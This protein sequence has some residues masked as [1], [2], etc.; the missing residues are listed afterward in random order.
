MISISMI[1]LF[2]R[3]CL[4]CL[5]LFIGPIQ[6]VLRAQE[7]CTIV[8]ASVDKE[9][10]MSL[11]QTLLLQRDGRV[12]AIADSDGRFE[13]KIDQTDSLNL[14]AVHPA[15]HS[16]YIQVCLLSGQT[17]SLPIEL[18]PRAHQLVDLS[19]KKIRPETAAA[20]VS[21]SPAVTGKGQGLVA[22]SVFNRHTGKPVPDVNVFIRG[23]MTHTRTDSIGNFRLSIPADTTF[24]LALSHKGYTKDWFSICAQE[25]QRMDIHFLLAQRDAPLSVLASNEDL[26]ILDPKAFYLNESD[27]ESMAPL[28][29]GDFLYDQL[30]QLLATR[31]IAAQRNRAIFFLYADRIQ[32]NRSFLNHIDPFSIRRIALWGASKAPPRY[33][34][35]MALFVV[36]IVTYR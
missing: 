10:G 14:V 7:K 3:L 20:T 33:Q 2:L 11:P 32:W 15:Y 23:T 24:I 28:S 4:P 21:S 9:N 31:D 16:L 12:L 34:T 17:S 8:G 18:V 29:F 26:E 25:N 19:K 36:E 27:I 5:L 1:R 6:T 13:I 22:G 35:S 30:P